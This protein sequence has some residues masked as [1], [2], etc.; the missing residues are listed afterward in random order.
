MTDLKRLYNTDRV[1]AA[2]KRTLPAVLFDYVDGDA[3]D[4]RTRRANRDAFGRWNLRQQVPT[5]AGVNADLSVEVVG[6]TLDLPIIVAPCG[7]AALMHPDGPIGANRAAHAK[8]TLAV[9]STVAGTK[10][11]D[12]AAVV[13][14]PGWFQLYAP[15]GRE[16][17]EE[18][19][20][21]AADHRFGG[22]VI[23]TDTAV[24]GRRERDMAHGV[25]MPMN[26]TAPVAAKL[27]VEFLS[28]PG[29]VARTV[30]HQLRQRRATQSGAKGMSPFDMAASPVTWDDIAWIR[31]LWDGPLLIKGL[32]DPEDARRARDAGAEAVVVSN[33]GGRQLDGAPAS[34]D[35]LV[36]VVDAVGGDIDVIVDGGIRRGTDVLKA[37]SLGACAVQI[38]RPW[39]FGLAVGGQAGVE[40]VLSLFKRE[41]INALTLLDVTA[42][43]D[44]DRSNVLPAPTPA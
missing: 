42:V 33:H 27:A 32:V 11:G 31:E 28:K 29:W 23:T 18:L 13:D 15:K 30:S 12:L 5:S 14:D 21:E 38:G 43:R 8:G 44:L 17:A 36:D 1:R 20:G 9:L 6:R 39:L 25:I 4:G 19:I 22:L 26:L 40:H 7:M 24:L 34:L 16:Q 10:P 3:E 2:A 37:L 35:A 41:L